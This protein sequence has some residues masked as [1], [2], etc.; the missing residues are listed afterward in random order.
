MDAVCGN[1]WGIILSGGEGTRLRRFIRSTYGL[2]LPKQYCP[3]VGHRSMLRHTLDRLKSLVPARRI[4]TIINRTHQAYA[5]AQLSDQPSETILAQPCGRETGIGILLPLLHIYRQDSEAVVA[6]FPSDHFVWEEERFMGYVKR[7][8]EF[9]STRPDS[10][11]LMGIPPT[12]YEREYGWIERAN[13]IPNPWDLS[14][15]EIKRFWEKPDDAMAKKLFQQGC[16]WN[17]FV[18]VG[19]AA[20]FLSKFRE[21]VPDAVDQLNTILQVPNAAERERL[22]NLVYPLL[23]TLNFS[24]E[25][26]EQNPGRLSVMEVRDVYWSDWGSERRVLRDIERLNLKLRTH[27]PL[28][29]VA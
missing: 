6:V 3:L 21:V 4:L 13:P 14:I 7:C 15:H 19:T 17:T 28:R 12:H 26:L 27:H 20:A 8:T 10:I 29:G 5:T 9:V 16:L 2:V 25:V 23:P 1:L 18:M 11:A 24:K 22:L